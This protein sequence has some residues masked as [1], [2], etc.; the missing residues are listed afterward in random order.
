MV[1]PQGSGRAD[2]PA[3]KLTVTLLIQRGVQ[4]PLT[5]ARVSAGDIGSRGLARASRLH[6]AQTQQ[7]RSSEPKRYQPRPPQRVIA[8]GNV[9]GNLNIPPR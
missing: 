4:D 7:A 2:R 8:M 1:V 5:G 3:S 6:A 9:L